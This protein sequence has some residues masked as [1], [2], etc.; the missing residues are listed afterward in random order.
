[1][2]GNIY[3]VI[4]KSF[5]GIKIA[6][7]LGVIFHV[8]ICRFRTLTIHLFSDCDYLGQIYKVGVIFSAGDGCNKCLCREGGKVECT[9]DPCHPGTCSI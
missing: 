5:Y 6:A 7:P 4:R 1:M 3:I 2:L 8:E 9:N